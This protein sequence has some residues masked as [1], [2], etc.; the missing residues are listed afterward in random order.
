MDL[1][2]RRG[3]LIILSSPSGA[4]KTTL[5]RRLCDWDS[6][7][8]LSISVTTRRP[9]DGESDGRE[10]HFKSQQEF[11]NLVG[12]KQLLEHARVF[13]NLY[14]SPRAPVEAAIEASQDVIFDI[15]WQGGNQIRDSEMFRD[16]VS[17]F[18]LPPS[19]KEL[20]RR[21]RARGKDS[22]RM[23]EGRMAQSCNEISH[24]HGYDYVLVNR[25]IDRVFEKV[26]AIVTAERLRR[27]RHPGL[28]DFVEVLYREF[29]E[30]NS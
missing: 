17:I 15:D 12:S 19:I 24:W 14:G 21:L 9:R 25:D 8:T 16:T 4:G 2:R 6:S 18:V 11:Q 20:A 3:M 10:Y 28:K 13:G 23:L 26:K 5:A 27:Y 29:D 22:A 7:I 1:V 30:R